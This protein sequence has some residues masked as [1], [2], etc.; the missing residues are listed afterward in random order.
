MAA[1]KLAKKIPRNKKRSRSAAAKKGWE[2]RKRK[3]REAAQLAA[4]RSRAAKKGWKTRRKRQREEAAYE[5]EERAGIQQD[6][7]VGLIP[8]NVATVDLLAPA[9]NVGKREA[10]RALARYFRNGNKDDYDVFR[11][12]KRKLYADALQKA[13]GFKERAVLAIA[14]PLYQLAL[15]S[16][17]DSVTSARFA[18][19]S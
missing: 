14:G 4:K 10:S 8:E 13:G 6:P 17:F 3:E 1:K 18:R 12:Y 2:T 19:L 5:R 11:Q 15:A 7:F 9:R 16:G